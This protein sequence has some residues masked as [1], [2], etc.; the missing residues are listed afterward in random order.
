MQLNFDFTLAEQRI[1]LEEFTKDALGI[2][3]NR[4]FSAGISRTSDD[5]SRQQVL[6]KRILNDIIQLKTL[7]DKE[8][9]ENIP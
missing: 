6:L 4:S 1:Y 3:E 2:L 7:I 9:E 5:L 8:L